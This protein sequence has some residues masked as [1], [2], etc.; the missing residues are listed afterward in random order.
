MRRPLARHCEE[1]RAVRAAVEHDVIAVK[2]PLEL[3]RVHGVGRGRAAEHDQQGPLVVLPVTHDLDLLRVAVEPVGVDRG[4]RRADIDRRERVVAL[5]RGVR[6]RVE[7]VVEVERFERLHPGEGA[8]LDDAK[9]RGQHER[10][11]AAAAVERAGGD[12][13]HGRAV[14]RRGDGH[15]AVAAVIVRHEPAAALRVGREREIRFRRLAAPHAPKLDHAVGVL[16]DFPAGGVE[17]AAAAGFRRVAEQD[18]SVA[19]EIIHVRQ[20]VRVEVVGEGEL[21]PDVVLAGL[22]RRAAVCVVEDVHGVVGAEVRVEVRVR[23]QRERVVLAIAH[24]RA[25]VT[26]V[27]AGRPAEKRRAGDGHG[28]GRDRRAGGIIPLGQV[29]VR[30]AADVRVHDGED[31]PRIVRAGIPPRAAAQQQREDAGEKK[32]NQ[33][34]YFQGRCLPDGCLVRRDVSREPDRLIFAVTL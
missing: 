14:I 25:A 2:K 33:P 4:G 6:D 12:A 7:R 24:D 13:G 15:G 30:V 27:A 16:E 11:H 17:F 5:E 8:R 34:V 10:F 32:R 29:A 21:V 1:V 9:A 20:G 26:G 23:R 22:R 18:V 19:L 31:I 3:L 28:V